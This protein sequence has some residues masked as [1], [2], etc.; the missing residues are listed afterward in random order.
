MIQSHA[1]EMRLCGD[2]HF[3]R[4]CHLTLCPLSFLANDAPNAFL[5]I[6][7]DARNLRDARFEMA[8]PPLALNV[9]RTK[10]N[11]IVWTASGGRFRRA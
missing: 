1:K 8:L 11:I 6:L 4:Q 3:V 9:K 5:C 10:M 7:V 2:L